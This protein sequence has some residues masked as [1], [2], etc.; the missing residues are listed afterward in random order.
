MWLY[1]LGC[2]SRN[3]L[4]KEK[5]SCIGPLSEHTQPLLT[6][7]G[8]ALGRNKVFSFRVKERWLRMAPVL[9]LECVY[10]GEGDLATACWS[11]M[12]RAGH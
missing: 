10:L 3:Q 6:D 4:R 9:S 8:M 1:L 7:A 5:I 12:N 11:Q 2:L